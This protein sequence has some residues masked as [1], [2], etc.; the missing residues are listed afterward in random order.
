M[1][2]GSVLFVCLAVY[3][4]PARSRANELAIEY[5]VEGN[6]RAPSQ[7]GPQIAIWLEDAQSN[8]VDTIMVTRAVGSFGL[9]NRPGRSD[10]G[11]G[12]IWPAGRREMALP[13]WAHR[14]GVEYDRLVFQDCREGSLG[15]HE[16]QSSTEPFYCRP[17]TPAENM[18]D[19]ITCPTVVFSYDKGIA[20]RSVDMSNPDCTLLASLSPTT[21][22]PPRNDLN[23]IDARD[24]E[25][26]ADFARINELDAVSRATPR[27]AVAQRFVHLLDDALPRG[28]YSVWVE[29]N[30]EGDFNAT[31]NSSPYIDPML[32]DYGIAFLGQPSVVFSVPIVIGEESCFA[33]AR[34]Y[35]GY[36]S[37]TGEDGELRPPDTTITTDVSG[38]GSDRLRLIS[39]SRG[40]FRVLA[41]VTIGAPDGG[42]GSPV[43][44]TEVGRGDAGSE[45]AVANDRGLMLDATTFRDSGG[46]ASSGG[47][48]RSRDSGCSCGVERTAPASDGPALFALVLL[49]IFRG[50]RGSI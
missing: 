43:L 7:F 11:S 21:F 49:I 36:G 40:D 4:V 30:L 50:R 37:V 33:G 25:G 45:D 23:R 8:F 6:E 26:V 24:W 9:G 22:Y 3:L 31:Y 19:T 17:T 2:R 32:R 16:A 12:W 38:S 20:L 5:I 47:G 18:V 42:T 14:R 10:F 39:D 27:F 35:V 41:T 44:C 46:G 1:R 34:D 28:D 29:I 15:F 13:V 48:T